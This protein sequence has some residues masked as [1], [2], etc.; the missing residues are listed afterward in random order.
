MEFI[1][2]NESW[3]VGLIGSRAAAEA[4]ESCLATYFTANSG[5]P[6]N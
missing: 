6:F 3:E 4:L 2:R 5:D 1:G